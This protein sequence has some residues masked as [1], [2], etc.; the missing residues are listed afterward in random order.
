MMQT[1]AHTPHTHTYKRKHQCYT[2][3]EH[4]SLTYQ[5]RN[6][7]WLRLKIMSGCCLIQPP[8]SSTAPRARCPRLCPKS[9]GIF[10]WME[11]PQ[12]LFVI[13]D[14]MITLF[15]FSGF[16]KVYALI[17]VKVKIKKKKLEN[18]SQN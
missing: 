15:Q 16:F 9:F 11:T 4:H 8:L 13:Y 3:E 14:H 17:W 5:N 10:P 6:I 18:A 7:E 2:K 12:S 1:H